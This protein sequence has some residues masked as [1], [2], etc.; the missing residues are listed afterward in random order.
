MTT[1]TRSER[2]GH[3]LQKALMDILKK[4]IKDPRLEMVTITRV[5]LTKD[6][7]IAS[8]YFAMTGSRKSVE[9]VERAFQSAHGFLKKALGRELDLRYM[10]ELK[11]Y[12]DDSL[13]YASKIN[14]LF[15]SI[16]TD[17]GKNSPAD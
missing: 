5:K 3:H 8:I 1:F 2:V 16:E 12:Y 10:P 15:K 4:D 9:E 6:L 7:K 17:D 11:F 14:E 13:D